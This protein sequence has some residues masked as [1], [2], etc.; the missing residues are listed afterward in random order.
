MVKC[1]NCYNAKVKLETTSYDDSLIHRV[2]CKY[3]LFE[4]S[5][6]GWVNMF[7]IKDTSPKDNP[8]SCNEYES[9]GDDLEDFLSSLP[10]DKEDYKLVWRR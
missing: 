10:Y 4:G 7:S 5:T 8:H 2:R 9:M 6:H 1:A 3:G